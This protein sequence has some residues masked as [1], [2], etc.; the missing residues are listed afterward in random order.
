MQENGL[1]LCPGSGT[2]L[3][4]VLVDF[5]EDEKITGGRGLDSKFMLT[6]VNKNS[7]S[8]SAF[9]HKPHIL[10]WLYLSF[11]SQALFLLLFIKEYESDQCYRN[12]KVTCVC[13]R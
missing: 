10:P 5:F 3:P 11:V 9:L 12:Y 1:V 6:V 13:L 8:I 7:I 4:E 2:A